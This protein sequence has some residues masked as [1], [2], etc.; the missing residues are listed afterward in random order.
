MVVVPETVGRDDPIEIGEIIAFPTGMQT[1]AISHDWNRLWVST[2][3][4]ALLVSTTKLQEAAYGRN[5]A[6]TRQNLRK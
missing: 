5:A 2:L 6:F 4:G 1:L 3:D